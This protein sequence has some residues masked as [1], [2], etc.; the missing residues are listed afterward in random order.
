ME[1]WK[2]LTVRL[3]WLA[4]GLALSLGANIVT[5]LPPWWWP[6]CLTWW[7]QF[8][9][10]SGGPEAPVGV[11]EYALLTCDTPDDCF[12]SVAIKS[13]SG[14]SPLDS[15]V[16]PNLMGTIHV[17]LKI[18]PQSGTEVKLN[19]YRILRIYERWLRYYS[20]SLLI[21][22]NLLLGGRK[23]KLPSFC[24]FVI[25]TRTIPISKLV[26]LLTYSIIISNC[27]CQWINTHKSCTNIWY[28]YC[29]SVM[30][31]TPV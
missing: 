30:D 8:L 4:W 3:E 27:N 15:I 25:R 14:T 29:L 18:Q 26:S 17:H 12:R 13:S 5:W 16:Q 23:H 28:T 7:W 19:V 24:W 31:L 6:L 10:R 21:F 11:V 20:D 9:T 2:L 1:N 22:T